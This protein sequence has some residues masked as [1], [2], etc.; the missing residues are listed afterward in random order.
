MQ[1]MTVCTA[2]VVQKDLADEF[3]LKT[4]EITC[5]EDIE[6]FLAWVKENK[7]DIYPFRTGSYG[8][9]LKNTDYNVNTVG[10]CVA[11]E[12]DD[13]GNLT[14]M[15]AYE[16]DTFLDEPELLWDWYQKGY[17]RKDVASV[18]DD[19]QDL[20]MGKYAVF[21][22]AYKPGG[23][24]EYN[25]K[26]SV[27]GYMIKLGEQKIVG[28]GAVGAGTAISKNTKYPDKAYELLKLVNTNA[29]LI[30]LLS[31]GIEG[32]H[33]TLDENGC[34][35][36]NKDAGYTS[37]AWKYGNVFNSLRV[38]GQEEDVWEQTEKFNDEAIK[39]KIIGFVLDKTPI[40]TQLAQIQTV[41][42][43][44][45]ML[46]NGSADPKSY[47]EEYK[48]AMKTAGIDDVVKEVQRQIEEWQKTK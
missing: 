22:A 23:E 1:I 29:D 7:P 10:D 41:S 32:K 11:V 19:S 42:E 34:A 4:D 6:P 31:F 48:S 26:N 15:P 44:Y 36:V 35:V 17:I 21:R 2:I 38:P 8:G 24:A 43:K 5:L 39:S 27:K 9:G 46:S 20:N 14:Y 13:D 16:H 28:G 33:Y 45:Q 37:S 18:M 30:N 3:G 40:R 25:A 47:I 12:W